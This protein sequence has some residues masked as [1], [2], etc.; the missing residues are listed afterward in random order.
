[1]INRE[2]L[3]AQFQK[4]VSIDAP[5]YDERQ[6]ADYLQGILQKLGF[7]V[8]EDRAGEIYGGSCGNLYAHRD[9]DGKPVLFSM[10]MDTVEPSKGK[11][12]VPHENGKITSGGDTVLGADD[13][14]GV[15][16]VL[17]A[18][19]H[20][21]EEGIP[22]RETEILLSIGE[23]KHVKG[24]KVFEFS[25][26]RAKESFVLD[27]SGEIGTAAV[28]APSQI[29]FEAT[30]HGKAAHAGFAP[31]EGIHAVQIAARAVAAMPM[32]R[33]GEDTTVNVGRI[34]GGN[35]S[36]IVPGLCKVSG[37]LRSFSH[38]KALSEMKKIEQLFKQEAEKE[39]AQLTFLTDVC[40]RAYQTPM[41][42]CAVTEYRSACKKLKVPCRFL[43]TFGG[44]DQNKLSEHGI[45]GIVVA[46]AMHQ[47]HSCEEW[48]DLAEMVQVAEIVSQILQMIS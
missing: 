39:G 22:C 47:V 36:N 34:E 29:A 21:Q 13:M 3:A 14:S 37:E 7:D 16:A 1:M 48:T 15:A 4:L 33:I 38:E 18:L 31:Q 25:K 17:E 12:A 44:S 20:L 10:H 40:Y 24:A 8:E 5:S 26:I 46:S 28:C 43:S 41:D 30:V 2:R 27:L 19:Y 9:G 23:E 45:P 32:G 42:A 11:R 35:A 6:M